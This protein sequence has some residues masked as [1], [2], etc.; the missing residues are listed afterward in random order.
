MPECTLCTSPWTSSAATTSASTAARSQGEAFARGGVCRRWRPGRAQTGNAAPPPSAASLQ[1]E[2]GGQQAEDRE[3]R[4][5]PAPEVA[6]LQA[7]ERQ[8]QQRRGHEQ[9]AKAR[10]TPPHGHSAA[11]RCQRG[12][13]AKAP[14]Q[15]PQVVDEPAVARAR[16]ACPGLRPTGSTGAPVLSESS[17]SRGS[18]RGWRS[19]TRRAPRGPTA[20]SPQRHAGRRSASRARPRRRGSAPRPRRGT[21]RAR[22]RPCTCS[23]TRGPAR[24]RR[25]GSRA[26]GLCSSTPALPSSDSVTGASVGASLSARWA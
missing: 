25:A 1:R 9:P 17:R 18:R 20:R 14:R 6:A 4:Q 19:E 16:R 11:E 22:S 24:P 5:Q 12:D 3:D 2:D 23:R 10:P 8:V 7:H 15:R 13:P 26:S 21:A